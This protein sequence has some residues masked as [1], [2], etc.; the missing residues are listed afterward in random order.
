MLSKFIITSKI[1]HVYIYLYLL[2]PF[3]NNSIIHFINVYIITF[4]PLCSTNWITN[5][6][7]LFLLQIIKTFILNIYYFILYDQ[8]LKSLKYFQYANRITQDYKLWIPFLFFKRDNNIM[9]WND[10]YLRNF[11]E[12]K[13]V[14]RFVEDHGM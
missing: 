6:I 9:E 7:L 14:K 12:I 4:H 5:F 1:K 11:D 8:I 10:Q 2:I 13:I 3:N